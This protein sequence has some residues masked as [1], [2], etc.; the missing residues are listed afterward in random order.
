MSPD[1]IFM[2]LLPLLLVGIASYLLFRRRMFSTP[3]QTAISDPAL[4]YD[5][6]IDDEEPPLTEIPAT[7]LR[8]R[9]E[10]NTYGTKIP[11]CREEYFITFLDE[12]GNEFTHSVDKDT[13][14]SLSEGQ[15]G[16]V[17]IVNE[18][19]YGFAED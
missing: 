1:T 7:I 4:T 12:Y 18:K 8:M 16:T 3:K 13:Y 11:Q 19:F 15:K 10:I 2:I 17:A 9:C 6:T 5:D 14:L